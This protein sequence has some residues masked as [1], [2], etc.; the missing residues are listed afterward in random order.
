[1]LITER[2]RLLLA[3]IDDRGTLTLEEAARAFDVS[4]M[5]LHR[6]LDVLAAQGLVEKVRGGAVRRERTQAPADAVARPFAA[7]F[8]VRVAEKRRIAR[9]LARL[10]APARTLLLDASSTVY[11]LADALPHDGHAAE[12]FV[13]TGSLPLFE[14]LRARG[15]VQAALHGGAPHPRTGALVGR[16]ATKSL[17]GLR[18]DWAVVSALG[19]LPGEGAVFVSNPEEVDVKRAYLRHARR[20]ALAVDRSKLGLSGA[21]ALG[22]LSAFDVVVTEDGARA[23]RGLRAAPRR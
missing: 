10:L 22:P 14:K 18:F 21:F 2:R 6:D 7:R 23:P 15:D 17:E 5:T 11:F 8:G 12:L 9:H 13:V 4:R 16:L 1:V 20:K 19:V 3:A